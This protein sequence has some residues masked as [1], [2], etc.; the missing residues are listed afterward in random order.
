MKL[1]KNM[2]QSKRRILIQGAALAVAL[3]TVPF[4]SSAQSAEAWKPTKPIKVIVPYPPGGGSDI[5]TRVMA[6]G[7]GNKLGQS[8]IV[9]NKPGANGAIAT[10]FVYNAE[11]DGYTLLM[12]SADTYS[13]YPALFPNAKFVSSRFVPVAPA[14]EVNFV[15]M[16]RPNLTVKTLP[17]LIALAQKEKLTYSTWGNGSAAHIAMAQFLL[18]TKTQM[19]HVP[20]QG[21]APAAQAAMASQVDL[22]MVPAPLAAGLRTKMTPFGV[23]SKNRIELIKDIPTLS[24]SGAVVIA[25]SWVGLLAPPNT[26]AAIVSVIAKAFIEAGKSPEVAKRLNDA[27]LVPMYGTTQEFA[28]YI[29]KDY[30]FWGDLIRAAGIKIEN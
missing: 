29:K 8:I 16:G 21:A 20:Y 6:A 9:E 1:I 14:A 22:S 5:I 17:D 28:E 23:A 7:V 25:P 2:N 24:E 26:P 18:L 27:G 4:V 11:P 19:L 3:S 15:L 10:E 12:S 30:V 13:M